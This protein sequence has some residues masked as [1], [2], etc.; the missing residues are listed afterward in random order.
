MGQKRR[1]GIGHIRQVIWD[2][3]HEHIV[4][5]KR[6]I[7]GYGEN[8]YRLNCVKQDWPVL[9]EKFHVVLSTLRKI[10]LIFK[11]DIYNIMVNDYNR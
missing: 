5:G 7:G 8:Y 3:S 4:Q 1:Q 6:N 9:K 2:R 11:Y 10:L